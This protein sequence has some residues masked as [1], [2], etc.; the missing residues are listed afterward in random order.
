MHWTY[1][2]AG[3]SPDLDQGDILRPTEE[4]RENVLRTVHPHFVDPKYLAFM[5]TTQSC[6]LFQRG[7]KP[8]TNYISIAPVRSLR[9]VWPKLAST[10]RCHLGGAYFD[11]KGQQK[12]RDL[13]TRIFDQNEQSLGL[14]YLHP[15][16]EVGL[17]DPAVAYLR[18]TVALRAAHYETL[19]AARTAS[20]RP[21]FR[22]KFGWLLGNLYARAAARDWGDDKDDKKTIGREAKALIN[23]AHMANPLVWIPPH[24]AKAARDSALDFERGAD[25][26]NADLAALGAKRRLDEVVDRTMTRVSELLKPTPEQATKLRRLLARDPTLRSLV[27]D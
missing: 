15:D 18:V 19:L 25:S 10:L 5:V 2:E 23:G 16:A 27:P 17:G 20:L 13:L 24:D 7:G 4:L 1:A 3:T 9:L 21:D 11:K 26:V 6:D 14:F 22:A 12:A 8:S